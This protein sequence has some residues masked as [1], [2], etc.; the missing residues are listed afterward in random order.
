MQIE[1]RLRAEDMRLAIDSTGAKIQST[2]CTIAS[3][4]D[5]FIF[6]AGRGFGHGVGLCQYG[7]RQMARDGKTAQEI[8][9]FYYPNSRIKILY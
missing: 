7:A 5:E 2:S 3:L 8:L 4:K 1:I 9:N 6:V